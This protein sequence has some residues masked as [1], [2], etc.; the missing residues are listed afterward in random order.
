MYTTFYI[1]MLVRNG[2][3]QS[4]P[5][6]FILSHNI[7][8]IICARFGEKEQSVYNMRGQ[9][10]NSLLNYLSKTYTFIQLPFNLSIQSSLQII[11]ITVLCA[12]SSS[13]SS[14]SCFN[15]ATS[16]TFLHEFIYVIAPLSY[17]YIN[18]NREYDNHIS[19]IIQC[20][21]YARTK[22]KAFVDFS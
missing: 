6:R 19:L 12:D 14:L 15:T 11:I 18:D 21:K 17:G 4:I 5:D 3:N 9:K 13:A 16:H 7:V 22:R 10:E 2:W 1:L 20:V 8:C